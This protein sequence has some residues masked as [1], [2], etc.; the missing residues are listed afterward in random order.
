MPKTR[1]TL[2]ALVLTL[3][4]ETRLPSCL[5]RLTWADEILVVDSLST[6][7]T[8]AIAEAA[9][10]KV[11]TRKFT[12]FSDQINFGLDAAGSE[13]TLM[14]DADEWVTP[15][16]GESVRKT[17]ADNPQYEIYNVVRDAFF[18]GRLMRASSWSG[19]RLPRLFKKG[20]ISFT[21]MVHPIPQLGG[22]RV[23][24][25]GGKLLHN[26][27][28]SMEQYFS[29]FQHYSTLAARDAYAAGKR[30]GIAVV[31]LDAIWRFFHNY[32]IRGEIR[33]GRIGLLSSGLAAIYSFTKY[34]KLWGL[35]DAR[36]Q[37]A[38]KKE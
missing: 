27:N 31:F 8:V 11:L 29:K 23:G 2:T 24:V 7:R 12:G 38:E 5:E 17:L 1:P 37:A 10:A 30:P 9:G 13:W 22:R 19:E 33:D 28:V 4:E 21:S 14:V 35:E 36:R 32:L 16:L 18:L 25:L 6:D 26:T 34:A 3:N 15:E 20:S